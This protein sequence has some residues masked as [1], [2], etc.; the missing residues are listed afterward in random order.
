[1][2]KHKHQLVLFKATTPEPEAETP[3]P[4]VVQYTL[5]VTASE[6][7]TVSTEGGTFDDGTS[8]SVTANANEGY[9][10]IGWDGNDSIK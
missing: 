10:F 7:G 2:K 9:E 3:E 4:V 1:M 6:G 5:T 8:V